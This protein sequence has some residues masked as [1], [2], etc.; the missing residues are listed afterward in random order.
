MSA[1]RRLW[2]LRCRAGSVTRAGRRRA[3]PASWPRRSTAFAGLV[4]AQPPTMPLD[5]CM[6]TASQWRVTVSFR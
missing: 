4:A 5:Q 1:R 2:T 6:L 3:D